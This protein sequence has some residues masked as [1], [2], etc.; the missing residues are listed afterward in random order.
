MIE[1]L[2]KRNS[3]GRAVPLHGDAGWYGKIVSRLADYEDTGVDP[4][5]VLWVIDDELTLSPVCIGC[6]GRDAEG[7]RTELCG[8]DRQDYGRCLEQSKMLAE[9][10]EAVQAY[11]KAYLKQGKCGCDSER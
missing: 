2:T 3:K 7:R 11:L 6:S 5:D 1:R 8:Y 4:D 10:A 9:I